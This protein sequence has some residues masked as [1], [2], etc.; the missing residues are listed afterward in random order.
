MDPTD[1]NFVIRLIESVGPIGTILLILFFYAIVSGFRFVIYK[2]KKKES[3]ESFK[4]VR[5]E[6]EKLEKT[7]NVFAEDQ[8]ALANTLQKI[9]Q[10]IVS[11]NNKMC[12]VISEDDSTRITRFIISNCLLFDFVRESMDYSGR[13][14]ENPSQIEDLKDQMMLELKNSW[15]THIGLLCSFKF[16]TNIGAAIDFKFHE[17]QICSGNGIVNKIVEVTF[18]NDFSMKDKYSRIVNYHN[19]FVQQVMTFVEEEYRKIGR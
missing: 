13:F 19:L 14:K 7:T 3:E 16:P 17:D 12:N 8:I 10:V 4:R 9:T 18:K 1:T 6:F 15:S 5:A 11:I 2:I